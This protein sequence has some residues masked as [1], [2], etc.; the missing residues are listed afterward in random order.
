VS[1][2]IL[3]RKEQKSKLEIN[4]LF[5]HF[6]VQINGVGADISSMDVWLIAIEKNPI[7]ENCESLLEL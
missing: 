2:S 7:Q 4:V 1:I 6:S 3:K 5:Y